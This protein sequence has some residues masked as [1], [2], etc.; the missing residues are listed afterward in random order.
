MSG[1]PVEDMGNAGAGGAGRGRCNR[2]GLRARAFTYTL[3]PCGPNHRADGSNHQKRPYGANRPW[4]KPESLRWPLP[5]LL[6]WARVSF[7]GRP[8]RFRGFQGQKRRVFFI[9][10]FSSIVLVVS[11]FC[12]PPRTGLGKALWIKP[13]RGPRGR[14]RRPHRGQWGRTPPQE[15]AGLV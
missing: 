7:P 10:P 11:S 3:G 1:T 6:L 14:V 12:G 4:L 5:G 8:G 9:F 13:V 2:L 15:D